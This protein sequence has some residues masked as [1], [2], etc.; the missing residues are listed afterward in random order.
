MDLKTLAAILGGLAI[1]SHAAASGNTPCSGSKGGVDRCEGSQFLC[2]DGSISASKRV[3]ASTESARAQFGG[4]AIVHAMAKPMAPASGCTVTS[5]TDGDTLTA[6]C[7]GAA[8]IR[9]RLAEIDAPESGQARG[10]D[11]TA[12]LAA[13]CRD[14][15]ATVR[16]IT[17]DR[18]GRSVARV[19]CNGHDASMAQV[20]AGWA[21]AF[22]KY[23]TDSTIKTAEIAAR[24]SGQ[25]LWADATPIPPWDWRHG[26]SAH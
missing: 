2:A 26:H 18:Y 23:L 25:G 11:S 17:Q 14:Q 22:T 24:K 1:G 21:W 8:P 16:V 3:C 12:A 19:A 4:P 10:A 5:I 6:T 20:Q 7:A 13:L 15:P 9:V